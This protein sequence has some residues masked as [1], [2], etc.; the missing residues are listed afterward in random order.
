MDISHTNLE[1]ETTLTSN[2]QLS[3]GN[4]ESECFCLKF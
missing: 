1:V 3:D 2:S 4:L